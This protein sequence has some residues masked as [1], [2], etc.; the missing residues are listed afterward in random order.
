MKIFVYPEYPLVLLAAEAA[1]P[2][3]QVGRGPQR[4]LPR[5]RARPRQRHPGQMALDADGRFLALRVSTHR[6]YRRLSLAIRP[7]HPDRC[8]RH[9][10]DRRLR[11]PGA[12][13]RVS[14][15]VYTN[16]VPVDAYRGAGRPEAAYLLERLVDACRA[17]SSASAGDEIRR[18]NFIRPEQMPYR[19][20]DRPRPTT[21]ASSTAMMDAGA[22]PGRTGP[23]SPQRAGGGARQG[24][25]RGIGIATYIEACACAGSET[26]RIRAQR[27]RHGDALDRHADQRPGPRHRLCAVRSPTKLGIASPRSIDRSRATPTLDRHGGGTGGSRSIPLGGVVCRSAPA[28]TLAEKGK[29]LAARRAGG[30]RGRHRAGRRQRRASSAPTARSAFAAIAKAAK[31]PR[32]LEGFGEFVQD[33]SHLSQRLPHLRG[34]DRSRH[35]RDRDRPLHHRRRFR[36]DA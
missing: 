2:A 8:R 11:H 35:R 23:A 26:G 33:E 29:R 28:R 6:Q 30:G 1:R 3:G 27:R 34:R 7:L 15:G 13:R 36:R 12:A 17:A 4:A 18:R 25:M 32:G 24:K 31:R 19:T 21:A 9:H 5:R 14:K 20:A 10:V 22:R 16:T